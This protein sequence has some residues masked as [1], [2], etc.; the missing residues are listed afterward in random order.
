MESAI[1]HAL[2]LGQTQNAVFL[3]QV[4]LSKGPTNSNRYILALAHLRAGGVHVARSVAAP[5]KGHL[6]CAYI[7]A[8]CC[9]QLQRYQDGLRWLERVTVLSTSID[10]EDSRK[11]PDQ[12]A[13]RCLLGHLARH[14]GDR[15]KALENYKAAVLASPY[16][17]EAFEG[18][19]AMGV[20]VRVEKIFNMEEEMEEADMDSRRSLRLRPA[21]GRIDGEGASEKEIFQRVGRGVLHL[22]RFRCAEALQELTS[23]PHAQREIPY[24]L[25][26]I[27]RAQFELAEYTSA[28]QTYAQLRLAD[29]ARVQDM[30]YYSTLLWHLRKDVDLSYLGHEMVHLD[31]L[32]PETWCAIGNNFSLARQHDKALRCFHRATGLDPAYAYAHTLQGHEHVVNEEFDKAQISFRAAIR[33]EPRHYNA[34]YGLGM[35]YLRTGELDH[36]LTHFRRACEINPHNVVLACCIGMVY[37][38][39]DRMKEAL[40]QYTLACTISPPPAA[41]PRFKKAKTLTALG[42]VAAALEEFVALEQI[43]PD[44]A[45]VHFMLGKLY[46]AVHEKPNAIRHFTIA[47]NLD[48]KASHLIKEAIET[49]DAPDDGDMEQVYKNP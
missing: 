37:E 14:T 11:M 6:P 7:Y 35:V 24:V 46:K 16:Q 40:Q 27:G 30:D 36:A 5:A 33:V 9:L 38:R 19:C 25:A 2:D 4:L 48:P 44:E 41:L 22:S 45:N 8:Q 1:W 29:P 49:L 34:W 10:G 31:R 26:K 28:E 17:W 13:V 47:L 18:L 12:A 32:A 20:E 43:A 39:Q 23:L 42:M 15:K 21:R 3:A